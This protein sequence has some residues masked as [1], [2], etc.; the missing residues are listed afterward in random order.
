MTIQKQSLREILFQIELLKRRKVQRFLLD[1]GL[2]PGQGQA[3]LLAYLSFHSSVTQKEIADRCM[4]DV[5]TMSRTLD[6]M[7]AAGLLAREDNP[8]CRRSY[9]ICLTP[10]GEE[11]ARRVQEIFLRYEELLRDSLT[12]EECG[13]LCGALQKITDR[14]LSEAARQEEQQSSISSVPSA[15]RP[16]RP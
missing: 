2:T 11:K 6:R 15:R 16:P 4:L 8:S 13:A 5:T 12:E 9:L 10:L 14:L 1:I 3:R 7:E